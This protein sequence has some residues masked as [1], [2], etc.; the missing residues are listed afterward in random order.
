[1]K[2]LALLLSLLATP[3]AAQITVAKLPPAQ[4]STPPPPQTWVQCSYFDFNRNQSYESNIFKVDA[5]LQPNGPNLGIFA[6]GFEQAIHDQFQVPVDTRHL[7]CDTVGDWRVHNELQRQKDIE[8]GKIA[9]APDDHLV[10][11]PK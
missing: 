7:R 5:D 4:P 6:Q 10:N 3:A 9:L 2:T 8:S 1:M 11:W